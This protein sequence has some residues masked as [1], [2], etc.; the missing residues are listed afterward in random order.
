MVVAASAVATTS[1]SGETRTE[2]HIKAQLR[3]VDDSGVTVPCTSS[4]FLPGHAD[5]RAREGPAAGQEVHLVVVRQQPVR[6]GTLRGGRCYRRSVLL[7][8]A[9]SALLSAQR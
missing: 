3:P 9:S 8:L 1:T 7:F 5:S 2:T 6:A 4:S